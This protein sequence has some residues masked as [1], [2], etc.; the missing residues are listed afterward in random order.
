MANVVLV[1]YPDRVSGYTPVYAR[2]SFPVLH[3]IDG[4][5]FLNLG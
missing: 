2:E 4:M 5:L 3:S 1:L